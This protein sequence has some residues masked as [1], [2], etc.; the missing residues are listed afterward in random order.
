MQHDLP[1]LP[2]FPILDSFE[3]HCLHRVALPANR[4]SS[5]RPADAVRM[6]LT[7][8]SLLQYISV[9]Y[10]TIALVVYTS[11]ADR[12]RVTAIGTAW[13]SLEAASDTLIAI[14]LII[15]LGHYTRKTNFAET[16]SLLRK[17]MFNA[18]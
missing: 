17:L 11:L 13:L 15:Q 14:A 4:R 12:V 8:F 5:E 16:Q 18:A 1:V 10:A 6:I 9:I 3:E 7:H 2:Y